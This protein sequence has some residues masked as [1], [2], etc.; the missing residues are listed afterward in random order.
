V[1][2]YEMVFIIR[3]DL[4]EDA[5]EAVIAKVRSLAENNGAEVTK[6]DKWGKRRLAYEI[7]H[8]RDGFYVVMNF[9]GEPEAAA[10]ID[11]VLKISDEILRHIIVREDED[12]K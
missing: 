9:N 7:K 8:V 11:R 6:L 12:E 3:P 10:E 5:L 1:R 2:R 4:E